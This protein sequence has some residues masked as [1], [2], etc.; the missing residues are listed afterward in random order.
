MASDLLKEMLRTADPVLLA[1]AS[2]PSTGA[3]DGGG[4][5]GGHGSGHHGVGHALVEA[6][7]ALSLLSAGQHAWQT[8]KR[9]KAQRDGGATPASPAGSA[10]AP[11]SPPARPAEPSP[12]LPPAQAP[13]T[14]PPASSA[15][16][17]KG[18][19]SYAEMLAFARSCVAGRYGITDEASLSLVED[20]FDADEMAC[21][22]T[23]RVSGPG[24]YHVLLKGNGV[25]WM[26]VNY[27]SSAD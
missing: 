11:G 26:P 6:A 13:P 3:D 24:R 19:L 21:R 1:V 4:D 12:A 14:P 8:L 15:P 23:F 20:E 17:V 27:Q 9:K 2:D 7:A 22:F 25:S 10:V 5:P 18:E 16:G